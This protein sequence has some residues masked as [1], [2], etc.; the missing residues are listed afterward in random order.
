M[1][2]LVLGGSHFVGRAIVDE[3][4]QQDWQVHVFNRGSNPL[5][6]SVQQ[7]VGDR[8]NHGSLH[9]A[10][11]LGPWD[12]VFDTWSGAPVHASTAAALL[13]QPSTQYVYVSSRSVY[14]TLAAGADES[15]D[16]VDGDPSDTASDDY[17][18]AKRGSELGVLHASAGALIARAGL[19][20]GPRENIGRLPW[21]LNR[22]A[23]GGSVLAPGPHHRPLQY[24]DARDLAAWVVRCAATKQGGVFNTVSSPGHT[25]MGALLDHAVRITGSDA[26]LEWLDPETISAAGI[27]PWSELPIWLPPGHDFDGLHDGD[28]TAAFA[29]GLQCRPME[30]T[31]AD[32]W[33]WMCTD[34]FEPSDHVR[35]AIGLSPAK[36]A[37]ALELH[38][39]TR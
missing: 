18:R 36:E 37:A 27:E 7:I 15:A 11:Q 38:G 30:E 3:C 28:V 39:S 14:A 32:T 6:G 20:L 4:L 13:S 26:Q 2:V 8:T 25:T 12:A 33:H 29:A 9:T 1:K 34:G 23:Q 10:A 5:P 16:C 22:I 35:R 24:I 21:W 17:A 31:V 19:I